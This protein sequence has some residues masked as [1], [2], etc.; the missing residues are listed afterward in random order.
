M[1]LTQTGSQLSGTWVSKTV[2]GTV[3]GDVVNGRL[4]KT[5]DP[6]VFWDFNLTMSADGKKFSGWHTL[7]GGKTF[8][9]VKK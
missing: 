5:D 3:N 6:E 8:N 7:Q 1:I 4:Y 2:T 9:G